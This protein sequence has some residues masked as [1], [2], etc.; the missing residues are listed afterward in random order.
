MAGDA[1]AGDDPA[2]SRATPQP[3]PALLLINAKRPE[4]YA[5]AE[6]RIA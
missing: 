4:A 2:G 3:R 5:L 1:M 6:A